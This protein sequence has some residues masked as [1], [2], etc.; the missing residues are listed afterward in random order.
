MFSILYDLMFSTPACRRRSKKHIHAD[1]TEFDSGKSCYS[2]PAACACV[3]LWE[4]AW[5]SYTFHPCGPQ[6]NQPIR[7]SRLPCS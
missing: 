3:C 2:Y 5:H 4:P 7:G 1:N 6:L